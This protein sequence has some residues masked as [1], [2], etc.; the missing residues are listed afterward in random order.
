MHARKWLSN[1]PEVLQCIPTSDCATEVDL[2]SAKL[3]TVKTLGVL[4]C[5]M[6]DVFK[7]QV[8]LPGKSHNQTKRSF[9]KKIATL[10][11]PLGQLSPYTVRAKVLLQEMW[12]SGVDWDEPI[13]TILSLRASQWFDEL[14]VLPSLHIPRCLRTPCVVRDVTLHT[15]VDASQEAYGAIC[16]TRHVYEDGSVSCCLVASRSRVAPLK[17]VSIPRLELMAAVVGLKLCE[18]VG[19]VLRIENHRWTFWSDRMDVLYWVRGRSRKFKPFVANR[20]GEIQAL[21]NPD[22]WRLVSSRQNPADLLTRG[23]SVTKLIDEE[24]WWHGPLFLKQ[25]PTGWPENRVEVKRGPD[26]EVRKSYQETEQVEEQTFL[27]SA[28]EDRLKPQK[29][30]S[31]S[32]LARVTARVDRFIENC[33]LPADLRR[34]GSLKPDEVATSESRYIRQAQQEVFAEEI[35]AVKVGKGLPSGS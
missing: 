21:T 28:S 35:R 7:F 8:N 4:W 29:Y 5:P 34:E 19:R 24:K 2:D 6:D 25:D 3:P 27:G 1:V 9:L 33:S 20:M 22:Q 10:F 12:A 18:T 13:S 11:D 26:I 14:A 30:S 15:F 31:W 16:Y 32:K 23:L 17:A